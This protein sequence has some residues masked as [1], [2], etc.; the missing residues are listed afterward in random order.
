MQKQQKKW[1]KQTQEIRKNILNNVSKDLARELLANEWFMQDRVGG[2]GVYS[3]GIG[4]NNKLIDGKCYTALEKHFAEQGF[5]V[6]KI[7]TEFTQSYLR[8]FFMYDFITKN[9][10][11]YNVCKNL[12]KN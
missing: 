1:I 6:C 7:A 12:K 8:Q 2:C 11:K 9:N 4:S 10:F 5:S 3:D